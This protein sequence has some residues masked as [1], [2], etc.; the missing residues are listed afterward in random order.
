MTVGGHAKAATFSTAAAHTYENSV[1]LSQS[2]QALNKDL[3]KAPCTP[4]VMQ[5]GDC[6]TC[7]LGSQSVGT[8]WIEAY[9]HDGVCPPGEAVDWL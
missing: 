2:S 5:D 6:L 1:I 9:R 3:V 8:H 4:P 7:Q